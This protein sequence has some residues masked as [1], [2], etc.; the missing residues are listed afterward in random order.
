MIQEISKTIKLLFQTLGLGTKVV[1][2]E[3]KPYAKLYTKGLLWIAMIA[4]LS[5]IP[6]LIIG[7][8][9]DLRWL[10]ALTGIW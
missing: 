6:F 10:I 7:I 5:P 2:E 8:A 3:V 1:V 4:V 9:L